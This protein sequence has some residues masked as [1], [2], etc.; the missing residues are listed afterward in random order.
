VRKQG[1]DYTQLR[2]QLSP[3][4]SLVVMGFRSKAAASDVPADQP[5]VQIP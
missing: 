2:L 4:R 5:A 1:Q 3:V